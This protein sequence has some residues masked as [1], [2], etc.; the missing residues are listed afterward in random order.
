M[1][2]RF[3]VLG[4]GTARRL[5][6]DYTLDSA[7]LGGVTGE[8]LITVMGTPGD[9]RLT[10]LRLLPSRKIQSR[11]TAPP[12]SLAALLA[13][14]PEEVD[15]VL[16]D[17][18]DEW[19]GIHEQADGVIVSGAGA[20]GAQEVGGPD[21]RGRYIPCGS[22]RHLRLWKAATQRFASLLE[23]HGLKEKTYVLTHGAA[24]G[25]G[26]AGKGGPEP[27][28]R[29]LHR[30]GFHVV[31]EGLRNEQSGG[32]DR[33]MNCPDSVY[34]RLGAELA[35]RMEHPAA[36]W[37]WDQRHH[38]P[39]F[40]W[41]DPHSLQVAVPGRT[42]HVVSPRREHN[43]KFPL[44]FLLQ[45][46]GSDTLIVISHGALS[47][48]K[49][50][51]PR[52]EWLATLQDRSEN[53][54]FLADSA[55]EDH[56]DLELA[57][58][59]GDAEDNLSAR[60]ANVVGR[61]AAQLGSRKIL[62]AGGSGGGFASMALAAQTPQ[63]RALVFNPQ[64]SIRKYWRNAVS[65][66]QEALFPAL[67]APADLASL[68]CRTDV[69]LQARAQA[70]QDYQVLYVQNDSDELHVRAHLGPFASALGLAPRT[71][72][73]GDGNVQLI[74]DRFGKGHSMPYRLVL[75]DFIDLA[76]EDWGAGLPL[77]DEHTRRRILPAV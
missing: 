20:D 36:A 41:T 30:L 27:Y 47:R 66:Y 55:L 44:R 77:W 29:H 73:T 65:A 71:G 1:P 38:A 3:F 57:W 35:Q 7:I 59:T 52:F 15:A 39:V 34:H 54:L 70:P 14:R 76:L 48:T 13:T 49:Y 24:G 60:Y 74:V 2:R 53:L 58:Y 72:R 21:P 19:P 25:S 8:S 11:P 45:N 33:H 56:P 46:N 42:E 16:W 50:S 51:L 31:G 22:R 37:N 18:A 17:L 68:G 28:L 9:T 61:I 32:P 6:A 43:E 64:T 10:G 40:C 12:T 69:V 67:D 62:F 26:W 5:V 4:G 75:N 63:S 23:G